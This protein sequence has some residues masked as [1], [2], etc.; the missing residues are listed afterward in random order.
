M[1]AAGHPGLKGLPVKAMIPPEGVPYVLYGNIM[2]KNAPHPNA[3]KALYRFSADARA[4]AHLRADWLWLC[5]RR[6]RERYP[7]RRATNLRRKLLGTS[8]PDKQN[9]MI[10]LARKIYK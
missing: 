1:T 9:D 4:A 3:A 10:E 5:D 6:H 2:L 8:D 7:G